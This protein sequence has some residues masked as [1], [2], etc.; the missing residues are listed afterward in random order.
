MHLRL[1]WPG[2]VSSGIIKSY[3]AERLKSCLIKKERN[4]KEH[5]VYDLFERR[6]LMQ[7]QEE[8]SSLSVLAHL[9]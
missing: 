7:E 3:I 8:M 2:V 1:L 6:N 9:A 4:L 5:A